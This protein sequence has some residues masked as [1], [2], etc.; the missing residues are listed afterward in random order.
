VYH[1]VIVE[2]DL[3]DASLLMWQ[4]KNESHIQ[5]KSTHATSMAQAK[6]ILETDVVDVVVLDL[7][8]PDSFGIETFSTLHAFKPDIPIVILSG[9]DDEELA[10]ASMKKGAQDYMVKGRDDGH[11]IVRTIRYAVERK[12]TELEM[13]K[14]QSAVNQENRMESLGILA[15]GIVHEINTPTQFVSANLEFISKAYDTLQK[16]L[17]KSEK[18]LAAEGDEPA[19]KKLAAELTAL[20]SEPGYRYFLDELKQTI[21]ES[22][23]GMERIKT[24]TGSMKSFMHNGARQFVSYN[25]NQ[26]ISDAVNLSRNEWKHIARMKLDFGE[27]LPLLYCCPQELC[28]VFLNIVINAVH[29]IVAREGAEK[30]GEMHGDIGI[31]SCCN[32]DNIEVHITDNGVGIPDEVKAHIFEPFFTTK[33]IG[34]GSGLGLYI[35]RTIVEELG[36]VILAESKP[37][38]GA[39]FIVRL[40]AGE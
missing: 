38:E 7:N 27:N 40:R 13:L 36:G 11:F 28:Q 32:N 16:V 29:A 23:D 12:R 31:R 2:D 10:I 14:L 17:E 25:V 20:V 8:L 9:L 37:G 3:P 21:K 5:W 15:S 26:I 19:R 1:V 30:S 24:I 34:E 4:L 6:Q 35:S 33:G 18:L 22:M 39:R